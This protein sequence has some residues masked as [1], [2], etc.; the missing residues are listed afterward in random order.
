MCKPFFCI[1]N[2]SVFHMYRFQRYLPHLSIYFRY[3]I[4]YRFDII[5]VAV[6]VTQVMV[7]WSPE[8]FLLTDLSWGSWFF[9][10]GG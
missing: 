3:P 10:Y 9:S 6:L 7:I 5:C 2:S 8:Q 4:F 1:W